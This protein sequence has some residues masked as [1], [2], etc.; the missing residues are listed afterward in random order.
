MELANAHMK[1]ALGEF[2]DEILNEGRAATREKTA[3]RIR[4]KMT[5]PQTRIEDTTTA[6][7]LKKVRDHA[8]ED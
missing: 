3:E 5:P 8:G 1:A 4:A 2:I 6:K 7:E